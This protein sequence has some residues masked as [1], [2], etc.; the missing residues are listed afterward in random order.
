ML[1]YSLDLNGKHGPWGCQHPWLLSGRRNMFILCLLWVSR[2][3]HAP[4][5]QQNS[6]FMEHHKCHCTLLFFLNILLLRFMLVDMYEIRLL[7][8]SA[9]VMKFY[10]IHIL[11]IH[12]YIDIKLVPFLYFAT[13]ISASINGFEHVSL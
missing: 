8:L 9:I 7:I 4:W 3:F 1:E 13:T 12:Y 6:V 11:H 10:Y 5:V 2:I